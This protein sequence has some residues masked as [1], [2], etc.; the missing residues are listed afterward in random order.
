MTTTLFPRITIGLD[1][2]DSRS[3]FCVLDYA[4][5]VIERGTAPTTRAALRE[6]CGRY[7]RARVVVEVGTHSPWVS[8]LL[9]EL[10]H[11]VVVANARKVKAISAVTRKSDRVDAE[12]LAR[13]GRADR[14]L[15][16]PITHRGAAAQVDL[17]QLRAR[18][19]VVRARTLLI[20]HVQGALKTLG[21]AMPKAVTSRAFA[22]KVSAGLPAALR[23]ALE[24]ALEA[25]AALTTAIAGYDRE[26][27]TIAPAKY[28]ETALLR[29]VAGV[30]PL[31]ALCYV[32]TL[33]DPRRFPT[34]RSVGAYVGLVPRRAQS[35]G[36]D[37]Q[38]RITKAG[39]AVLRRLL[40][41]AAHYILGPFGPPCDLRRWGESL[42]Q[43]GGTNAKKRA[44]VAVARKLA[45]VLHRLWVTGAVYEPVR[46]IA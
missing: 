31:T 16:A 27:R 22:R 45:S 2:G 33:E 18:D 7:P 29:Q 10:G 8:R 20:N 24:R 19:A 23:P 9:G 4:G 30:G 3:T 13:L 6:V 32:L 28:P 43:R 41:T 38:L 36:R 42:M 39:D 14:A 21:E 5:Q 26:L 34:S 12:T 15:L 46:T 40:V 44:V 37:P 11:D 17:A 35:G 1:L 25:I